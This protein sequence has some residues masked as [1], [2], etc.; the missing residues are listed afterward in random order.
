MIVGD[1]ALNREQV[2]AAP[3]VGHTVP[4]TPLPSIPPNAAPTGPRSALGRL[5]IPLSAV[6]VAFGFIA[7]GSLAR[8]RDDP[9]HQ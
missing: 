2:A 3:E 5:A 8:Q 4:E 1:D 7:L 6:L 9:D